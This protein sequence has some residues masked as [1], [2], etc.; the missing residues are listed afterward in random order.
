MM[1]LP[2]GTTTSARRGRSDHGD[3]KGRHRRSVALLVLLVTLVLIAASIAA[4]RGSTN[5]NIPGVPDATCFRLT[6]W[7][8]VAKAD[9]PESWAK[10]I[11]YLGGTGYGA[12]WLPLRLAL[13]GT[14]SHFDSYVA[15]LHGALCGGAAPRFDVP[16]EALQS[17]DSLLE[18]L[19]GA[20]TA[21]EATP[22]RTGLLVFRHVDQAPRGMRQA[23]KDLFD[24]GRMRG[25]YPVPNLEHTPLRFVAAVHMPPDTEVFT[26]SAVQHLMH[27]ITM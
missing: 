6:N 22:L 16:A 2:V 5:A 13:H 1:P 25:V 18:F 10:H 24:S 23:F 3:H 14:L 11:A 26:A 8:K 20:S 17:P 19:R 12:P 15:R 27:H 7:S 9:S 4:T 21:L